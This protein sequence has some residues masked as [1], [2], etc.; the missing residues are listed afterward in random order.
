MDLTKNDIDEG[1]DKEILYTS[2]LSL[3]SDEDRNLID[4]HIKGNDQ[5]VSDSRIKAQARYRL[6]KLYYD[7]SD[8]N[9]AKKHFQEV[10]KLLS[11]PQDAIFM[12]KVLGFLIHI[13][14]ERLDSNT[15]AEYTTQCF[16]LLKRLEDSLGTLNTEYFYNLG[17]V[18]AYRGESQKSEE[19][20]LIAYKKSQEE[21][22]PEILAKSL[23]A[24]ALGYL[25][26][27]KHDKS[28]F[29]L[30]RLEELLKIIK[31]E[32]FRGAMHRMYGELYCEMGSYHKSLNHLT[33]ADQI[34]T[35]VTC[36]NM[37]GYILL[38]KGIVCKKMGEF[39][40]SLLYFDMASSVVDK[41]S[42]KK[43]ISLVDR[44]IEDVNDSNVDLY[45]DR[46]NRVV[47]ERDLGR[48]DFK[49]RF[50]L[51]EILFLLAQQP[52][53]Y[54]DKDD[55]SKYIWR[56]EYNPLIHDKLI[57]TSVSRLRKLIEPSNKGQSERRKYILRGKDGYTFN[58]TVRARFHKE[59]EEHID[60]L[61]ANVELSTPI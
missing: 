41:G 11:V 52:G 60:G 44:E 34:L 3:K 8:L 1:M 22:E 31:K 12:L 55:L 16:V 14:A 58:P 30:Q 61:V 21:N 56:E 25:R 49:H 2:L 28:L 10:L 35:R 54:F 48:I 17:M 18:Y 20:F 38:G 9:K 24:L 26:A 33:M 4:L 15:V 36:W 46:A 37:K 5:I 27:K 59:S 50:V 29:Y 6:A 40:K 13:A 57:Y 32:Y 51:L 43:L 7:K 45:L 42:F 39:S 53:I 47:Y 23:F 19:N